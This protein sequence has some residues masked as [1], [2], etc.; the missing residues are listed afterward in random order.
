VTPVS[1]TEA[2]SEERHFD[3]SASFEGF[4]VYYI[5]IDDY[6]K[7]EFFEVYFDTKIRTFISFH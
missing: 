4:K 3:I 1:K 7:S 2:N 6:L 5:F